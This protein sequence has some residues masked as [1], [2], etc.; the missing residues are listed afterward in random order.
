VGVNTGIKRFCVTA[1]GTEYFEIK[2][3]VLRATEW[4]QYSASPVWDLW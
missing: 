4:R 3:T 2:F 1:V